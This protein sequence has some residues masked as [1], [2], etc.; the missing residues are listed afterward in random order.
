MNNVVL[1][2]RMTKDIEVRYTASQMAVGKFT[3]AVKRYGKEDETDF[4][5]VTVFGKQAERAERY[6]GKGCR[7]TV[8]G[9]IQT[10]SYENN[11]GETVYTTDVI[12]NN[13]EYIDF[14]PRDEAPVEPELPEDSFASID[15]Q[16]PF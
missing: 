11:N 3:L 14:K 15:E 2:G 13:L 1:Q 10:D 9:R 5:R 7:V 6:I 16:I 8:Q 4:I 12:A